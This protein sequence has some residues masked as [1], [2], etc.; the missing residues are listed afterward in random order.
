MYIGRIMLNIYN[1]RIL[2][3]ISCSVL[4]KSIVLETWI[5]ILQFASNI[6]FIILTEL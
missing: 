1:N 2:N 5:V 4:K 6:A 3:D